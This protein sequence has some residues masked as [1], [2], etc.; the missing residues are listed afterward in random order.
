M[1]ALVVEHARK[2][3]AKTTE[4]LLVAAEFCNDSRSVFVLSHLAA[5]HHATDPRREIDH[6]RQDPAVCGV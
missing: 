6:P 3:A 1:R 5:L 2:L 4:L